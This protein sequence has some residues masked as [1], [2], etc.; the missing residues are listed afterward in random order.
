MKSILRGF[1]YLFLF[2]ET[3]NV[4][5]ATP[6]LYEF[7]LMGFSE[8]QA[9]EGI[10]LDSATITSQSTN[11][12]YTASY[13]SGIYANEGA[14][15]DIYI[16]FSQA[17]HRLTI[18][19]GDGAGDFDAFAVSLYEYAT[20]NFLGT[21][22]SPIFG[23]DQESEWYTLPLPKSNIG[24]AVFDPGNAGFLPGVLGN[25]GGVVMTKLSYDTSPI[26][27]PTTIILFGSGL[28]VLLGYR[29]RKNK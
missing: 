12:V 23:G 2:T 13:G 8:N 24:K 17:I 18:T 6:F 16:T 1:L 21:W 10:M 29:K 11:L 7:G 5:N 3:V 4:A 14:D 15:S 26:P 28:I 19:A 27:E 9:I 25:K 20:G 22:D